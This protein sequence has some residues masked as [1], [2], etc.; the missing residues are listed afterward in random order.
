MGVAVESASLRRPSP[1]AEA[2]FEEGNQLAVGGAKGFRGRAEAT[3]CICSLH[4]HWPCAGS[5]GRARGGHPHRRSADARFGTL[6]TSVA[7][8]L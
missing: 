2:R 3:R 7:N 8:E 6:R 5:L 4:R 1:P